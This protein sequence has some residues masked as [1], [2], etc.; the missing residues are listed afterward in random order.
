MLDLGIVG[1]DRQAPTFCGNAPSDDRLA[2]G[3]V[4]FFLTRHGSIHAGGTA[5][6]AKAGS[7]VTTPRSRMSALAETLSLIVECP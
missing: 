3:E 4:R 2:L 5:W 1:L 6:A 7:T